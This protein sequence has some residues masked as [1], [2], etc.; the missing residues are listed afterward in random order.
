MALKIA[1][2]GFK[3]GYTQSSMHMKGRK[4]NTSLCN[5]SVQVNEFTSVWADIIN[6]QCWDTWAASPALVNVLVIDLE[7]FSI[8][9]KVHKVTKQEAKLEFHIPHHQI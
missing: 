8:M 4:S 7:H 1:V 6:C 9:C 3:Y 5:Q 2:V